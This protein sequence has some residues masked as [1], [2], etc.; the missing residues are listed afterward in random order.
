M[1]IDDLHASKCSLSQ[2]HAQ[3]ALAGISSLQLD[4]PI[5]WTAGAQR[6]LSLSRMAELWSRAPAELAG[7]SSRK[8]AIEKGMD[9][10]FVVFDPH[11]E[12]VVDNDEFPV[13]HRHPHSTPFMHER[14]G[15]K[16]KATFVRGELVFLE[17]YPHAEHSASGCGKSLLKHRD[18]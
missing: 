10:E 15:G 18:F 4:L 11:E 13:Y 12:F 6:G 17:G 14:L 16:V 9:A 1:L 7:L 2:S 5:T 3:D 8:G